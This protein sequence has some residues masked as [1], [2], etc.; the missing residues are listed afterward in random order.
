MYWEGNGNSM[1]Q[2]KKGLKWLNFLYSFFG[3]E[4]LVKGML[5]IGTLTTVI[6]ES[7]GD[8]GEPLYSPRNIITILTVVFL[9]TECIIKLLA[10]ISSKKTEG[11]SLMVWAL[12]IGTLSGIFYVFVDQGW[13]VGFIFSV[14]DLLIL[15]FNYSYLK[16]RKWVYGNPDL[17]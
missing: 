6:E 13:L 15:Y 7:K 17:L 12:W 3:L 1:E 9:L 8:Q 2:R 14:F 10:C 16:K 11:Y 4:I 5:S